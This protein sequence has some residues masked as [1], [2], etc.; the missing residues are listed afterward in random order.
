MQGF[1]SRKF[2]VITSPATFLHDTQLETTK[3]ELQ[4][5]KSIKRIKVRSL[6]LYRKSFDHDSSHCLFFKEKDFQNDA[7]ADAVESKVC[8]ISIVYGVNLSILALILCQA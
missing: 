4:K 7:A 3:G 5:A 1:I 8:Q 6:S 2:Y